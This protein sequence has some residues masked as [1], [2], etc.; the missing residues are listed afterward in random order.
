M[1][2][3]WVGPAVWTP[4]GNRPGGHTPSLVQQP[5]LQLHIV[6][7]LPE[8]SDS[9]A[10]GRKRTSRFSACRRGSLTPCPPLCLNP[11]PK[12]RPA[13]LTSQ[14][15]LCSKAAQVRRALTPGSPGRGWA[16]W[17][18]RLG[19]DG[20]RVH[21][22]CWPCGSTG[23]QERGEGGLHCPTAP[24][25]PASPSHQAGDPRAVVLS[26]FFLCNPV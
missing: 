15:R 4:E 9:R 18:Q 20:G 26:T 14:V 23:A 5:P 13:A 19:V 6:V 16:S 8:G 17:W 25:R 22:S 2:A 12:C 21:S 11:P 7:E 3:S 10:C 24:G 1:R